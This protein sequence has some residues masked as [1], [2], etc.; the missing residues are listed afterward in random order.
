M[1]SPEDQIQHLLEFQRNREEQQKGSE[2]A[3]A[4]ASD[5]NINTFDSGGASGNATG[6]VM[7]GYW[8]ETMTQF[9]TYNPGDWGCATKPAGHTAAAGTAKPV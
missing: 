6:R 1:M 9:G 2:R 8:P 7:G 3:E 5:N 4:G